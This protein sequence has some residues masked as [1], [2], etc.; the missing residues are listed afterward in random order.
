LNQKNT[1]SF[2][3]LTYAKKTIV[4]KQSENKLVVELQTSIDVP[5]IV[6]TPNVIP[7]DY[8]KDPTPTGISP[9]GLEEITEQIKINPMVQN[10]NEG[11]LGFV[12]KGGSPDQ[13]L[14][15]MDGMPIYNV[16]HIGGLSSIFIGS[17]VKDVKLHTSGIS[18]QYGG[19]LSSVM[20]LKIKEGNTGEFE[21]NRQV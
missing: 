9:V 8:I 3:S 19:K 1:L 13:N 4:R 16:S 7:N 20:D 5:L 17:A 12:I 6:I 14:I 15:L 2:N 10:G 18:A 11:Q 21:G